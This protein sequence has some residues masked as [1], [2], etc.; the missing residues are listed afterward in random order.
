MATKPKSALKAFPFKVGD[1]VF[2]RTV[3][4]YYLGEIVAM[5]DKWISLGTG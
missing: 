1:K 3:T 4:L 2:I 5:D